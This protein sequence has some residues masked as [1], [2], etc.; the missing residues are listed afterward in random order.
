MPGWRRKFYSWRCQYKYSKHDADV[1]S[2]VCHDANILMQTQFIQ[3]FPLFSNRGFFSAWNQNIFKTWFIIH[4]KSSSFWL[5][6]LQKNWWSLLEIFEWGS[7][8]NLM[9]WLKRFIFTIWLS[10]RGG[11]FLRPFF[12]KMNFLKIKHLKK[13][14]FLAPEYGNLTGVKTNRD[15]LEKLGEGILKSKVQIF[16]F[17]KGW[18]PHKCF[19]CCLVVAFHSSVWFTHESSKIFS[20]LL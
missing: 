16:W 8:W 13:I 9:I 14:H 11:T 20:F 7:T 5:K 4:E 15:R 2:W 6:T 18:G 1:S 19:G 12:R 3:K 17:W 10:K